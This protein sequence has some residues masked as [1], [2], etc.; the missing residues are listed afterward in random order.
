MEVL[1]DVHDIALLCHDRPTIVVHV[2]VLVAVHDIALLLHVL[3]INPTL[4]AQSSTV[5]D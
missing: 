2:E 5:Q 1:A 3:Q 4:A